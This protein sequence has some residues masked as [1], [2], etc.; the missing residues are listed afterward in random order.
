MKSHKGPSIRTALLA[1]STALPIVAPA[2]QT[3]IPQGC[4]ATSAQ[5]QAEKKVAS[6]F[7][8]PGITLQEVFALLDPSYVQHNPLFV[9]LAAESH[10]SG[11]EEFK[12][13]FTR[14][15]ALEDP[16]HGG[17]LNSP[18]RPVRPTPQAVIVMAECDLVTVITKKAE[19][20]PTAAPGT[21][22]QYDAFDFDMFR[23]RNG[24]LVEHWDG[25]VIS[26]DAVRRLRKLEFA[27]GESRASGL[28]DLH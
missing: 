14:M 21:I 9:K 13:M 16:K 24:K 27:V 22:S 4:R 2:Q 6:D 10:I 20:D 23:V 11:Y 18:L 25:A 15:A 19:P 17:A 12:Q 8:R 5:L 3:P 7:F 26:E 28:I 1:L